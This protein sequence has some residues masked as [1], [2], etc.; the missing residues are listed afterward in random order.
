MSVLTAGADVL[1]SCPAIICEVANRNANAVADL[2]ASY[3][4]TIYDGN[5]QPHVRAPLALA[6]PTTLA[7]RN[8]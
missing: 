6:P 4:Y 5:Q 2:L 3:G 8:A 7:V 1:K